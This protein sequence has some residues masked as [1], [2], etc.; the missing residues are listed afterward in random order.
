MVSGDNGTVGWLEDLKK[1]R[2][3]EETTGCIPELPVAPSPSLGTSS[4]IALFLYCLYRKKGT[5]SE[6]RTGI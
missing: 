2:E 1:Q 3:G 5:N 4:Q 6:T